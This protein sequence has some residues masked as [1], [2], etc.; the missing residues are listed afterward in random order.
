MRV[1]SASD[2]RLWEMSESWI[3]ERP[4]SHTMCLVPNN[5]VDHSLRLAVVQLPISIH[6]QFQVTGKTVI[7][8][9]SYNKMLECEGV[10]EPDFYPPAELPS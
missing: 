10:P 8:Q 5:P 2:F 7:Q 4:N 9:A 3:Q 6:L 1:L